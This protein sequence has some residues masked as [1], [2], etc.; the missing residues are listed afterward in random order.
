MRTTGIAMLMATALS[1]TAAAATA[2][3]AT[4]PEMERL[5][6]RFEQVLRRVHADYVD[7]VPGERLVEAAIEGMLASL[8][9]HSVFLDQAAA[10]AQQERTSG[11]FGGIGIKVA[12]DEGGL[13]IL[14]PID[15]GPAARA[16]LRGGDLVTRIDG[17]PVGDAGLAE[18]T[19]RIRGQVGTRV[20]LTVLRDGP[21]APG[22]FDVTLTRAVVRASSVTHRVE[23]TVGYIRIHSFDAQ[24]QRGLDEAVAAIG[25]ELG[26]RLPDGYVLDLRDNPGGLVRQAV[27]VADSFLEAGTIVSI[28]ARDAAPRVH[29]AQPGDISHGLPLAVLINGGSASSSEIVTGAL[30]DHGRA[31]VLGTRSFGKGSVQTVAS[32]GDWGA[33]KLTTARYYTPSGRSIHA[34]GIEPDV[35]VPPSGGTGSDDRQLAHALALVRTGPVMASAMAGP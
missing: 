23:G 22:S 29:D 12:P 9:P 34:V 2:P 7:A 6:A 18:T 16:G 30:Q 25:A 11:K 28:R 19:R 26:G 17:E 35:E 5:A 13:R 14:A 24:A 31:I 32:L 1:S 33:V 4:E 21:G 10:Q 27:S 15:G 8:D 3:A 20:T